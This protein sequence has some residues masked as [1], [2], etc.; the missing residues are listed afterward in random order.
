MDITAQGDDLIWRASEIDT[1]T[2]CM[3]KLGYAR[4][5]AE[6]STVQET[7]PVV[8]QYSWALIAGCAMDD[9]LCG[10]SKAQMEGRNP[11]TFNAEDFYDQRLTY[12]HREFSAKGVVTGTTEDRE[13]ALTEDRK[14]TRLNSSH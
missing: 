1:A 5:G 3:R 10:V 13:L 2:K 12:H 14:S 8:P 9:A 7:V 4:L 11:R 6:A